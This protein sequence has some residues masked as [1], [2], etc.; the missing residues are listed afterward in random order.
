MSG[1]SCSESKDDKPVRRS[2]EPYIC[3]SHCII[4]QKDKLIKGTSNYEK[5]VQNVCDFLQDIKSPFETS[6]E[7]FSILSGVVADKAVT[8]DTLG[9]KKTG[10]DA[11]EKFVE[12]YLVKGLAE[13]FDPITKNNLKSFGSMAKQ[14]KIKL[15]N[16]EISIK[17]DRS[18]F[19]RLTVMAQHG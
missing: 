8:A 3:P 15:K 13:F 6:T 9:A 17:A 5:M 18:L 4:C 1:V 14:V 11:C 7:L 2:Q 16:R 19:A 12:E 10:K